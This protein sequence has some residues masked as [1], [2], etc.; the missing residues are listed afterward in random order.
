VVLGKLIKVKDIKL[1]KLK[2]KK[3]LIH[4]PEFKRLDGKRV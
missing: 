3:T 4:I 1:K 2:A